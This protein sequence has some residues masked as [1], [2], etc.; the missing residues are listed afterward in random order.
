MDNW[1]PNLNKSAELFATTDKKT[2]VWSR[3]FITYMKNQFWAVGCG[4]D[5]TVK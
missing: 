2:H 1:T 3:D 5:W 4:L